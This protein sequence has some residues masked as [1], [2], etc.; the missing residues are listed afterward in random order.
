MAEC[1][2]VCPPGGI[3]LDP[4][5]GSGSTGVAALKSGRR[6]LG[7]EMTE[8]YFDVARRRLSGES[9]RPVNPAQTSLFGGTK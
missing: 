6:F 5:C 9:F 2:R 4:F 3:V 1:I 7:F 8:H